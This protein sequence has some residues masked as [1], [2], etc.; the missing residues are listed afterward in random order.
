M[1]SS[2]HLILRA[3]ACATTLLL[4]AGC[5]TYSQKTADRDAEFRTGRLAAAAGRADRDGEKHHKGKDGVIHR[6]EQGA[7]LRALSSSPETPPASAGDIV[8]RSNAAFDAAEERIN[9]YEER[10]KVKVASE[11]TALLTNLAN[12]P[13]R[14]RAYDKVMLNTYKALNHLRLGNADAARVELNR[15][16][17]RQADAVAENA[18]RIEEAREEAEKAAAGEFSNGKGGKAP[19][20]DVARAAEG[21]GAD[22]GLAQ[23]AA[24]ADA[25]ASAQPYAD[26][27]NPFS[28]LLDGLFFSAHAA[29]A[30]DLEHARKSLERAAG[31]APDNTF[32]REDLAEV[33]AGRRPSGVTY[34]VFETGS[35][36][37][38]DQIA[39]NLPLFLLT[40]TQTAPSSINCALPVLKFHDDYLQSITIAPA[41]PGA[42]AVTP[43]LVCSMDSV[44]A[45]DFKNEWPTTLTKTIVSAGIKAALDTVIQ[46]QVKDNAGG[47]EAAKALTQLGAKLFTAVLQTAVNIADTRAW[48]TLPKEFHYAR[49]TTP[50]DRALVIN[51]G[52]QEQRVQLAGG[53]VNIVYIKSIT[54][55]TPLLINQFKLK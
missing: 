31:M 15:A 3:A 28:V 19:A 1:T 13:Y 8:A 34:V 48:R 6:L 14:G 21:A 27:V 36:P 30:A 7:I 37:Y 54:P 23:A 24:A 11:T 32:V 50:D 2:P 26:Y 52:G 9:Q 43:A 35:G 4:L 49:L 44:V 17:Q 12:L 46:K 53:D 33:A 29:D 18:R 5:S 38:R 45:R 22:A 55:G 20:F 40:P 51:A 25:V 47:N 39:I 41:A 42:A 16:F 10:A